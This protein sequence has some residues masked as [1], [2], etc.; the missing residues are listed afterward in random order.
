MAT[1]AKLVDICSAPRSGVASYSKA[2]GANFSATDLTAVSGKP[3]HAAQLVEFFN[4]GTAT[5]NAV[6]TTIDGEAHTTPIAAGARWAPA[7]PVSSVSASSDADVSAE[8]FWWPALGCAFN[9]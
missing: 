6:Y 1:A 8:V 7:L 3:D 5:E 9:S 2:L 4:A